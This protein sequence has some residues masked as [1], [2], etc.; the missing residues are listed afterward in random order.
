MHAIHHDHASLTLDQLTPTETANVM[1]PTVSDIC[2]RY[3]V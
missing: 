3:D 2:D 1:H